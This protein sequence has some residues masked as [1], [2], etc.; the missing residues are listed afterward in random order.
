MAIRILA[1]LAL[2]FPAV[3]AA[4]PTRITFEEFPDGTVVRNQYGQQG[5]FFHD[6]FLASRDSIAHSRD[7]V[8]YAA[9]PGVEVFEVVPLVFDF[10]SG[11]RSVKLFAG[12]EGGE[13]AIATLT[14]FD[15]SGTAV[16][17]DGPRAVPPGPLNTVMQ[18]QA[19]GPVIRRVELRYENSGEIIDDL[20]F[21][22]DPPPIVPKTPPRI[23]ILAPTPGQQVTDPAFKVRGRVVGPQ[24][25]PQAT[26]KVS[27]LRPPGSTVTSVSTYPII[28][29]GTGNTRT[30]AQVVN[31]GVGPITV[32]ASA[33]NSGGHVG[34]KSVVVN[35]LPQAIR[36]RIASEGGI[37][38]LGGFV[39]GSLPLGPC[40]YAVYANA[41]VAADSTSTFVV[42][43]AIKAKWLALKDQGG[44][45]QL[46]CPT[47]DMR[48][49][50]TNTKAQDFAGGR[51]YS[52]P[53]GTAYVPPVF[54][55]AIDALGGEAGTGVPKS[56]PTSDSRP[57]YKTWLFQQ[58]AKPGLPLGST[59]EIRDDPPTLWVERQAGDGT[60]FDGVIK[61]SNPTLVSSFPCDKT[62]GPAAGPCCKAMTDPC[63][64]TPPPDDPAIENAGV[65]CD[66]KMF[67]WQSL[68]AHVTL[69]ALSP[70]YRPDPPE[71]VPTNFQYNVTS[72][73][74]AVYR[75]ELAKGD[76]PFSHESNFEPCPT[77]LLE[78]L[79][80]ET[81]CPS[82]WDIYL[83]PLPEYRHLETKGID[84]IKVEFERVHA[85]HFTVGW[86]EPATGDLLFA[87]GRHIVD[88][89]H[90]G[91]H[92]EI[93]PPFGIAEVR[94]VTYNG[95]PATEADIWVNAFFPGGTGA[96]D[97]IQFDVYPP[98]RPSPTAT[99]GYS[100][101]QGQG[102]RVTVAYS[103]D[104]MGPVHFKATAPRR[105]VDVDSLGQ[106]KWPSDGIPGGYEGKLLV[107]WNPQ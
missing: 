78:A 72:V 30:F 43:G 105:E 22:G 65:Y 96:Y 26:I 107:F 33:E 13:N 56:D 6:A 50:L 63:R 12:V 69:G 9:N 80:N 92:T 1:A 104:P 31:L 8:L 88:C 87:S 36:N 57:A 19:G 20:E 61:A 27:V 64:P 54:V 68:L 59:L 46:G 49:V 66:N 101:P 97:A 7:R 100:Y 32:T 98:P 102:L 76:N 82:D 74:G 4:V 3:A 86:G 91:Y 10:A 45:P 55:A 25:S 53:P 11:Q 15:A 44:F 48:T 95:K 35:Y 77:P 79:V 2:L 103:T 24:I 85:Q 38:S 71:W 41:A 94:S 34:H 18:V 83:K 70:D 28:L 17:S 16:A 89:G 21:D 58:F 62:N 14:A 106:M 40:T 60:L 90:P 84:S 23:T 39:F 73:W 29:S 47:S 51:I 81:I 37:A 52:G 99:L 93:H 42:R 75:A 5:V 67:D